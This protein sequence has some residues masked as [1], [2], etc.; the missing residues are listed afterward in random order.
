MLEHEEVLLTWNLFELPKSWEDDSAARPQAASR[1]S[2]A[3][4]IHDHRLA[5]LDY[6][7]PISEGRG[8][9]TRVDRGEYRIVERTDAHWR[10]ELLGD[11]FKGVIELRHK[12]GSDWELLTK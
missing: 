9:V 3:V 12:D 7:G 8:E 5:Y 1:G 2:A 6:E 11:R 4:K 10:V